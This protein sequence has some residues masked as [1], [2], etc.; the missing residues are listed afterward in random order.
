[1]VD[2]GLATTSNVRFGSSTD[3]TA[4]TSNFRFALE[5]GLKSDIVPCPVSAQKQK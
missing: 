3:L 4:P 5:S 1:M 2:K